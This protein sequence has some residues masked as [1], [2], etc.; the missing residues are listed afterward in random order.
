MGLAPPSRQALFPLS[1]AIPV[2]FHDLSPQ[3]LSIDRRRA[4]FTDGHAEDCFQRHVL[5]E[6]QAQLKASLL[7]AAFFYVAFGVTD[8]ATLG[9]TPTAWLLVALRILVAMVAL[10][11]HLAL[12]RRPDSVRMPVL[13]AS[14]LLVA[15]LAIFMVV[16]W[17]QPGAMAWNTMSQALILMA[18]YVNFPNR[19][20]YAVAIGVVSSAVFAAML[21]VQGALKA[22]DVLT[23]AL[24]LILGNALGIIAARRFHLSQREEFRS[25]CLL[26]QMADRDPLTGCYN[27]RVVQSGLLDAE[28]ARAHRYGTALS[29]ILCDIDHF[30]RINDVHGHAAGDQVLEAFAALL[31]AMTREQVDRVIRYGGEEFLVVLPQTGLAGAHALAERIRQAFAAAAT[32][33]ADGAAVRATASFGIACLPARQTAAPVSFDTLVGAADAELYAVKRG[34]RNGVRGTLVT[35][36]GALRIA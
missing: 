26:Q 3:R 16:A 32:Q 2:P 27:R 36:G 1:P 14:A 30:K 31:K 7:F 24:L 11:G 5:P 28:L 22:D 34:G 18:V 29:V 21:L 20:A 25:A 12:G 15:A 13:A 10:G 33:A 4:E 17:C 9:P 6:R 19:Y 8:L 23:L 35:A